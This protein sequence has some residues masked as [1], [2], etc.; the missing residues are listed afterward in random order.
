MKQNNLTSTSNQVG[1]D[2]S[3]D[4]ITDGENKDS[5]VIQNTTM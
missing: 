1:S 4:T 5:Y 3:K 2:I